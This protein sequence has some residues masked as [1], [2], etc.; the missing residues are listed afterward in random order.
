MTLD[1][2]TARAAIV[3]ELATCGAES[4]PKRDERILVCRCGRACVT[5]RNHLVRKPDLDVEVVERAVAP[6]TGRR[7]DDDATVRDA[8]LEFFQARD[9]GADAG[10]ERSGV[11]EVAEGDLQRHSR[12]GAVGAR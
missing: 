4:I 2:P 3:F 9:Q 7:C 12:S 6:M 5:D 1:L 11:V 10:L 8:R